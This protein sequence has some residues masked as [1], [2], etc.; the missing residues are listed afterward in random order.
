MQFDIHSP[1]TTV[2]EAV[3]FSARLRLPR[4]VPND[5]ARQLQHQVCSLENWDQPCL[6]LP[7]ARAGTC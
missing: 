1:Q 3:Y 4:D 5:Q 6:C 7:C 2:A